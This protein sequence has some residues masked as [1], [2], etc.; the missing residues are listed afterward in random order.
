M[1]ESYQ[2]F[3]EYTKHLFVQ[4]SI[5]NAPHN[6]TK[7]WLINIVFSVFVA[8]LLCGVGI[9]VLFFSKNDEI[10]QSNTATSTEV[11][12]S[13]AQL[14]AVVEDF[15]NQM[16]LFNEMRSSFPDMPIIDMSETA[17]IS[18][19]IGEAS[20]VESDVQESQETPVPQM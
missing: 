18:S 12:F 9:Y 14:N 13:D 2:K 1:K 10:I 5:Q 3:I 16:I 7:S 11:F 6:V 20:E 19:E 17:E 4:K 15:R 8:V